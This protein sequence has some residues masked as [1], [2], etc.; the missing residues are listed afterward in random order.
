[1]SDTGILNN[2]YDRTV[3]F[4]PSVLSNL[5][6]KYRLKK[7]LNFQIITTRWRHRPLK[8]LTIWAEDF[9]FI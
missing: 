9:Y 4:S 2:F 6:I 7:N 1:M 3:L 5:Q 8:S